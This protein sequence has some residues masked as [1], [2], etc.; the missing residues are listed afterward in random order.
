[1]CLQAGCAAGKLFA[2]LERERPDYFKT[3]TGNEL[4]K[5]PTSLLI[6]LP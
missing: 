5:I 1:M 3:I 2:I 6:H 4:E